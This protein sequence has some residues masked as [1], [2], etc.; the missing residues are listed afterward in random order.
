MALVNNSSY[1]PTANAFLAHWS[2]VDTELGGGFVLPGLPGVIPPSLNRSGLL[3]FRDTLENDLQDVQEKLNDVEIASGRIR[4][5]KEKL[6]ARFNL[7]L[8]VVDGYYANSE[9][10]S[11]R[12]E[13]PGITAGGERFLGP[14][15]DARSLWTKLNGQTAP[16]GLTVPIV[17]KAGTPEL[18][19]N[20]SL[21]AFT[22]MLNLLIQ[23]IDEHGQAVQALTLSRARRDKTM[24]TIRAIL[25]Q[26][27][28]T[29]IVPISGNEPL[30]NTLPRVT[31]EPGHTPEPV[32]VST[33]FVAPNKATG[34]H[35]ESDDADFEDYQIVAA[36]GEEATLEDA[37]VLETRT[38]R[39][40]A[41]FETS[42]GLAEP[43]GAVSLWV[44]V[45]TKDGNERA[46]AKSLVRRPDAE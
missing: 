44:I 25:V 15:R 45:R 5:L 24:K 21:A 36:I 40:P 34:S 27:R 33:A 35:T 20:V 12:P 30:L 16:A 6:Y 46:S 11:A 32:Q 41:P 18:P 23:R 8:E 19:D 14:M 37:I 26:Y 9:Y 4:I 28:A 1:I 13:A 2:S 7:F 42:M 3:V 38:A 43:G 22:A 31:P 29:V 39:T 10:A 17:V